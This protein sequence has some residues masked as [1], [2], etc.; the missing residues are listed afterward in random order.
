ML[1]VSS[2]PRPFLPQRWCSDV[3]QGGMSVG[4]K[5]SVLGSVLFSWLGVVLPIGTT[6][7]QGQVVLSMSREHSDLGD[8]MPMNDVKRS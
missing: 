3:E 1:G 6:S 5:T 8:K 2:V 4:L 7:G